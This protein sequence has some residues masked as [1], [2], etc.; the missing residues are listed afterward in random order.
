MQFQLIEPLREF[1][2]MRCVLWVSRVE[3]GTGLSTSFSRTRIGCADASPRS[4][5]LV[6]LRKRNIFTK[7]FVA[8]AGTIR[9]GRLVLHF[10]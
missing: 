10:T 2:K 9:F 5:R 8:S 3:S 7:R 1:L 4:K 6:P